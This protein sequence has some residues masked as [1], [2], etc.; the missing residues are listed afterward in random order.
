NSVLLLFTQ[1]GDDQVFVTSAAATL[2]GIQ[3]EVTLDAGSGSNLLYVNGVGQTANDTAVVTFNALFAA[4]MPA[5]V[6]YTATGGTFGQG[7]ILVTGSGNDSV[8]VQN[9]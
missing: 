2:D 3:G 7:V 8:F 1:G 4:S 5:P 9:L 6:V